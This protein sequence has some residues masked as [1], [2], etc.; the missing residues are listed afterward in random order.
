MPTP[1]EESIARYGTPEISN[2][3]YDS[4]FTAMEFVDVLK[5][6]EICIGMDGRATWRPDVFV[7]R[8]WRSIQLQL[9]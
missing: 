1:R 9:T 5:R 4:Q 6:L 2:T 3:D 8:L 7:K